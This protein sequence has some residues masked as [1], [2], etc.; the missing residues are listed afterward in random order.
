MCILW[1]RFYTIFYIVGTSELELV[2]L[3]VVLMKNNTKI[4]F[5]SIVSSESTMYFIMVY[6]YIFRG[7]V[8]GPIFGWGNTPCPRLGVDTPNIT[9][10]GD[11]Q[12]PVSYR[13]HCWLQ[14]SV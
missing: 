6:F 13:R 12:R 4:N 7:W 14:S 2:I 3:L 11:L 8:P 1:Y 5:K 9:F 10:A